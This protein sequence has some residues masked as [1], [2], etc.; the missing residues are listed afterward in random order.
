MKI[1]IADDHALY[2]DG[3]KF[4]LTN[5]FPDIHIEDASS[6][7]QSMDILKKNPD[8]DLALI[9]LPLSAPAWEDYIGKM[10]RITPR[11]RVGIIAETGI[12]YNLKKI[13]NL[14]VCCYLPKN[15]E[16]KVLSSALHL[17]LNGGTYFPP[18][19]LNKSLNSTKLEDGKKLTHRQFEVLTYL[20]QGLSNKQ[21]AYQLS[22]SEATVKLHINALLRTLKA[23]NRTQAVIKAQKMGII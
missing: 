21:I 15:I 1:L 9:G 13:L 10:R 18:T 20:A 19:L 8:T 4:N 22:V 3:F 23:T 16:P 11:T 6:I 7:E 2:R 17:V 14:G 5:L 12:N